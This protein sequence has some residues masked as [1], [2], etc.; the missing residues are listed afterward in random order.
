[1]RPEPRVER[2]LDVE[3]Q[4]RPSVGRVGDAAAPKRDELR[5]ENGQ[6]LTALRVPRSWGRY[7]RSR[8][9]RPC[10]AKLGSLWPVARSAMWSGV[11]ESEALRRGVEVYASPH[12]SRMWFLRSSTSVPSVQPGSAPSMPTNSACTATRG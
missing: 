6:D 10:P 4:L 2:D 8:A 3:A 11:G 1:M 12:A 9:A 5:A 7:G